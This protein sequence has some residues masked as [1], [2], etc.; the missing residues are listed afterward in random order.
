MLKEYA[1]VVVP[2]GGG[3]PIVIPF[4]NLAIP[5]YVSRIAEAI[6][7]HQGVASM[8]DVASWVDDDPRPV[9]KYAE[10]LEQLD[11]GIRVLN[12]PSTWKCADSG[13]TQNLWLN[14]ST[15]YI[16]SGR[17][18]FIGESDSPGGC[19]RRGCFACRLHTG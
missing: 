19:P 14:L 9:S 16:G 5:E 4:P 2:A 3:E 13:E 7:N 12:D 15:G 8:N 6:I 17:K 10:G 1:L 18:Q 11:N